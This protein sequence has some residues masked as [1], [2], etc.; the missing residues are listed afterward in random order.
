M[1]PPFEPGSRFGDLEQ[2]YEIVHLVREEP[3]AV[4]YQAKAKGDRAVN[5]RILGGG[6]EAAAR[7]LRVAGMVQELAHA[8]VVPVL[9]AGR[10][11]GTA[12]IACDAV[13]G[14]SLAD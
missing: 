4:V 2:G 1:T 12:F 13:A 10:R 8:H 14:E 5:L 6:A 3:A 11:E 7:A 9:A